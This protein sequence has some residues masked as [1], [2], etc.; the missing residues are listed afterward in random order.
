MKKILFSITLLLSSLL[1]A[2]NVKASSFSTSIIGND[3]F[4]NEIILNVQ[5][6][7]LDDFTGACN[8]LCGLVGNLNYDA[9]KLELVS[10]SALEGF[11]L[12]QGNTLV[13]YK[14]TGIE[15]GTKV[16][17]MKFKNKSLVKDE[18]T[19]IT[20]SNLVASDGDKDINGSNVSKTI[21][22]IVKETQSDNNQTNN[23]Q[24]SGSTS[25]STNNNKPTTNTENN[26][27]EQPKSSNNY[28]SSIT[29]SS[30]NIDFKKDVLTYDIIVSYEVSNIEIKANLEDKK[31]TIT[32]VGK[33]NLNVGSN[34]IKLT[35]KAEDKTERTYTLNISREEEDIVVNEEENIQED[36]EI[37]EESIEKE[38]NHIILITIISILVLGGIIIIIVR[39][40]D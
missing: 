1:F 5:I 7:N 3:T 10:I 11:D 29:L 34:T 4:E 38:N 14:A 25:G 15:S 19:T 12:T 33:H 18:S 26:K 37:K 17:T 13:L 39:K 30:G 31:A 2:T 9:S 8:G 40:K 35:I 32:G 20:L 21:K 22:Y 23:D 28:L 36:V 16:L 24:T 6:N 27:V